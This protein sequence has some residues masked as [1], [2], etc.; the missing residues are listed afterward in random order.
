MFHLCSHGSRDARRGEKPR[1]AG[2]HALRQRLSA[3]NTVYEALRLSQAAGP[4]DAGLH[5]RAELSTGETG[6]AIDVS[7]LWESKG[8]R[9]L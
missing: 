6:R 7:S 3:G 1:L 8:D 5:A 2:A 9:G 4:R